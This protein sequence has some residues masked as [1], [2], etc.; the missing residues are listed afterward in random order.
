MSEYLSNNSL[1]W[2]TVHILANVTASKIVESGSGKPEMHTKVLKK[3]E[4]FSCL[5][6]KNINLKIPR[7]SP[8][9]NVEIHRV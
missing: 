6:M 8:E 1:F 5:H 9:S 4:N 7:I 2:Q 3:R